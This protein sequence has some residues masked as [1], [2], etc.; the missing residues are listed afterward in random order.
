[1]PHTLFSWT[2]CCVSDRNSPSMSVREKV[3]ILG[4]GLPKKG[5]LLVL[6]ILLVIARRH[7]IGSWINPDRILLK[8]RKDFT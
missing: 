4:L 8:A 5:T 2:D 1:M 7:G 6:F 3:D